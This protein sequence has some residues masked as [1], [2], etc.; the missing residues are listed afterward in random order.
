MFFVFPPPSPFA[1]PHLSSSSRNTGR[2]YSVCLRAEFGLADPP[3]GPGFDRASKVRSP[4]EGDE[5]ESS[6][7][8]VVYVVVPPLL[9]LLLLHLPVVFVFP[10]V[11][12]R[13]VLDASDPE[14]R[15]QYPP[16]RVGVEGLGYAG[17]ER[18]A[19]TSSLSLSSSSSSS[20]SSSFAAAATTI[21]PGDRSSSSSDEAEDEDEDEEEVGDSRSDS[22]LAAI[23]R[24]R[25]GTEDGGLNSSEN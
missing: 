4:D 1:R 8:V 7:A 15:F 16:Y 23:V 10:V 14:I 20:S 19:K 6:M 9:L 12:D 3:R 17:Q 22:D 24:E 13:H 2:T 11:C 25:M 18:L 5:S 21:P